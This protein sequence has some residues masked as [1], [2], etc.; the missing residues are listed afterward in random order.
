MQAKASKIR[1]VKEKCGGN[2]RCS[3]A[4]DRMYVQPEEKC[5]VVI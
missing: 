2:P 1:D 3:K 4:I 5:G